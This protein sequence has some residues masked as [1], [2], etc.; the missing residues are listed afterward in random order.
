M[1][2]YTYDED[3][4]EEVKYLIPKP[5]EWFPKLVS[6][7]ADLI[8]NSILT[9]CHPILCL[10]S[11]ASESYHQAEEAKETVE[12]AVRNA[13][14]T[15]IHGALLL[16]KKLGCGF[17]GAAYVCVLL[18]ML[19]ILATVVG[20][21]LVWLWLEEPVVVRE[22]LHFDYTQA[23]PKAVF[24]FGGA[25]GSLQGLAAASGAGYFNAISGNKHIIMGVPVGHTFTVSLE[26]L[27][28]ESDF[29]RAI[30]VSQVCMYADRNLLI[31]IHIWMHVLIL[32]YI[33][34]WHR[35]IS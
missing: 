14:S 31:H 26:L 11:I 13:P 18:I 8:Y 5:S 24:V 2:P 21:A 9:V 1:E 30:G 32:L 34:I 33:Y 4:A 20:I 23:H 6:L 7:Q 27:M 35:S 12:S 25:A 15:I 29:N 22:R 28:P 10:F 16:L 3:E 17:F 19:L